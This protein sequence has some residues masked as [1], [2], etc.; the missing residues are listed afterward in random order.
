MLY[1]GEAVFVSAPAAEGEIGF[2]EGAAPLMSTLKRGE[3]RI[4]ESDSSDSVHFAVAGGYL[5]SDGRKIVVLANHAM[6]VADVD[7]ELSR[8]R[9]AENEKRLLE[10]SPD[11]S[12]RAFCNEEI[13][14]QKHLIA[15]SE[16]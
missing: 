3:V 5:E 6:N 16:R 1:S 8:S 12:R 7:V 13:S 4:K 2:L 14:W 10:L 11:D 9:I 15:L